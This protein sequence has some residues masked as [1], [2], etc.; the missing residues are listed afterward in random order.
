[1]ALFAEAC[2]NR[3]ADKPDKA[4]GLINKEGRIMR[5]KVM[6]IDDEKDY[7]Y[8]LK[9]NLE[10][11][12]AYKVYTLSNSKWA[13]RIASVYKPS[14]ILLDIMMPGVDGFSVLEDLKKNENTLPIPVIMLT[15]LHGSEDKLKASQ[16]YSEEYLI[17]PVELSFLR[18]RID[19]VLERSFS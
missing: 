14:V 19:N 16:L 2:Q 12:G 17:K 8:F 18:A 5:K 7:C 15:A 11:T 1:M 3:R 10:L 9:T 6:I 13:A 4:A